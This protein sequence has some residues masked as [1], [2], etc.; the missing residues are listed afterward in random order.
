MIK[1]V[2]DQ[3]DLWKQIGK[4]TGDACNLN[5]GDHQEVLVVLLSRKTDVGQ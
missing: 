1:T 5:Q 3:K 2:N 4:M